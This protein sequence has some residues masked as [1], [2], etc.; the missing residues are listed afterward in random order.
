MH[1]TLACSEIGNTKYE[2]YTQHILAQNLNIIY[3]YFKMAKDVISIKLAVNTK[4]TTRSHKIAQVSLN[5]CM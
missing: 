3:I 4:L 5:M 1:N 2:K